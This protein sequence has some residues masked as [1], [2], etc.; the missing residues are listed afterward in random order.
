MGITALGIS[1]GLKYSTTKEKVYRII[2]RLTII[3]CILEVIKIIYNISQTSIYAVNEYMPLYY[4]SMLLYAG[5]LSSF[6]KGKLKRTG[7]VFLATGSIIGGLIFII[8][9]STSLPTYPA[10]HIVSLHSFLFHGIM[11]YLGILVNKTHYVELEKNDIKYFASLVGIMCILA[12]IANKI[13]DSNLMFISKNFHGMPIEI[14]YN[15]TNGTFV[16]T[17]IMCVA[18][19]T[20]PFYISYYAIK[21]I[22]AYK[23]ERI[24]SIKYLE[25]SKMIRS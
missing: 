14:L 23:S 5:L 19:M 6:G 12:L 20:L 11:I 13:F 1:L 8:Y 17:L 25:S 18:Q 24:N 22:N 9:P 16:F 4:C 2:K 7:D 3:M 21:K 15:M 10:Y